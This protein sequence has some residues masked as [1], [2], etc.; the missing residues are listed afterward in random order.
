MFVQ[1]RLTLSV[2][3]ALLA[4]TLLTALLAGALILITHG[5]LLLRDDPASGKPPSEALVPAFRV[6]GDLTNGN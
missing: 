4:T 1:R 2:L 3:A 6:R 5:E